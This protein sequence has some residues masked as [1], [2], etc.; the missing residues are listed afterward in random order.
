MGMKPGYFV[1]GVDDWQGFTLVLESNHDLTLGAPPH[2]DLKEAQGLSIPV[3]NALKPQQSSM[4]LWPDEG[5][6]EMYRSACADS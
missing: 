1:L 3:S 2:Y 5:L 6:K 4:M